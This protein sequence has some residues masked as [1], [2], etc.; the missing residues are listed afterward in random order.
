MLDFQKILLIYVFGR[1]G[2]AAWIIQPGQGLSS[3]HWGTSK[4]SIGSYIER[5]T[6]V[7]NWDDGWNRLMCLD[8]EPSMRSWTYPTWSTSDSV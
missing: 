3:L 2:G 4:L 1:N 6:S 8:F 7:T 5:K